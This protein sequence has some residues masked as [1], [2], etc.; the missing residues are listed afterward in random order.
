MLSCGKC[1]STLDK[2]ECPDIDERMSKLIGNER[3]VFRMCRVC[4]R[5]YARC[6]C[7]KPEWISSNPKMPLDKAM[8]LPTLGD[9]TR[10]RR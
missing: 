3:V 10:K 7:E 2:C 5:H 1:G 9:V 6:D 8:S 4:K